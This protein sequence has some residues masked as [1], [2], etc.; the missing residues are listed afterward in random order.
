M[1]IC[2]FQDD[3]LPLLS[4]GGTGQLERETGVR[5]YR[6]LPRVNEPSWSFQLSCK[7]QI[8]CH[9][10]NSLFRVRD[11]TTIG[12]FLHKDECK[13]MKKIFIGIDFSKEKFDATLI[14]AEG[15][16]E[17]APS[18]H[19]VFDNKASGYRRLARWVKSQSDGLTAESWIF[20]GENTG[21]YSTALSNYLYSCGY[22]MWLECAYRIKH[23]SGIQRVKNDRAD[24]RA[25]AE[26]AMRNHDKMVAYKPQSPS[27][28]RL[29]EVFLYRHSLVKQKVALTVRRSEKRLTQD[30]SDVKTFMSQT[31]RHLITEVNK[32]IGKCDKKIEEIIAA[33]DELREVFEIATSMPGV[34]VQN[35]TCLMVYTD[36]FAKFGFDAR[37]IGCYYGIAPFGK[38]SGTSVHTRPQVSPFANRMIKSLLSQAAL[39]A[40]RFDPKMYDY[41]QRLIKRGKHPLL[42]QN[43]VKNKILHTLTAM[44]RNKQKYNPD[45]MYKTKE[46]AA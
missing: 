7:V 36:N 19:E 15:L 44:V 40:I 14:K 41:Y 34:G 13:G 16:K 27:L 21:G 45:Y 8:E 17:Y 26:Y 28:A 4:K 22:D 37:K 6:P 46:K 10:H 43:N 5:D 2:I 24:S 31:S 39:A 35:A 25:I 23:S 18:A 20:C 30:K 9:W 38:D 12:Q 3:S 42:A 11:N 33:D 32:A 1:K 29:R